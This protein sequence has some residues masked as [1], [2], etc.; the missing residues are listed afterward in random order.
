MYVVAVVSETVHN[1]TVFYWMHHQLHCGEDSGCNEGNDWNAVILGKSLLCFRQKFLI[2]MLLFLLVPDSARSS[3]NTCLKFN[4]NNNKSIYKVQNVVL[5]DCF[6]CTHTHAHTHTHT[7]IHAP[8]HMPTLTHTRMHWV[9][10]FLV[11][12]LRMLMLLM[13]ISFIKSYSLLSSRLT[14][15]STHVTKWVIIAFYS[16]LWISNQVV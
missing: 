14:E 4:N 5:R 6:K 8:M 3:T 7:R 13:L 16:A 10:L 1:F 9:V 11:K 2:G 12:R 15:L